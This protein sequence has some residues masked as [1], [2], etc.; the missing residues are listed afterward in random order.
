MA[1][2][3]S[4]VVITTLLSLAAIRQTY[5]LSIDPPSPLGAGQSVV[6]TCTPEGPPGNVLEH[7]SWRFVSSLTG[8]SMS[9]TGPHIRILED[10]QQLVLTELGVED[11]GE[12]SCVASDPLTADVVNSLSLVVEGEGPLTL[13]Y[14][15]LPP[16]LRA[17]NLILKIK[18]Q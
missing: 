7:L 2:L 10:G 4:C 13:Y 5:S 6:F 15:Q 17:Y 9:A 18:L 16:V 11:S 12:W 1:A 3:P 14:V 8:E